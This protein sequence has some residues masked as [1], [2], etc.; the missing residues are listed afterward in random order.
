[1]TSQ[2]FMWIAIGIAS[3]ATA[4]GIAFAC[5]R[6]A[7]V[8]AHVDATLSKADTQLDGARE[9]LTNTLSSVSGVAANV[10]RLVAKIDRIATAAESA[11]T[12]VAKTADAAQAAVS[13]TIANLVGVVA[14][15]SQGAKTFFRTRRRNGAQ[16]ER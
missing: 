2:D 13:P 10:D 14:G 1:M 12:T 7:G 16:D 6:L 4:A 9:P 11:A 15:V 3:L 5:F 8:L